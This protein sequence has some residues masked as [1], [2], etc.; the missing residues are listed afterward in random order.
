MSA[1]NAHLKLEQQVGGY[2]AKRLVEDR[3][4]Q[5][6]ISCQILIGAESPNEIALQGSASEVRERKLLTSQ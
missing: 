4:E 3:I 5:I 6:Y 2:Q 1:I